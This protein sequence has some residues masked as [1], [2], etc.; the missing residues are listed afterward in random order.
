MKL[1]QQ[2]DINFEPSK[3]LAHSY[4]FCTRQKKGDFRG[5]FVRHRNPKSLGVK[6]PDFIDHRDVTFKG[7]PFTTRNFAHAVC[8]T[9]KRGSVISLGGGA[10]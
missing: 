7:P 10:L 4:R 2:Y 5:P 1:Q 6:L 8:W 9:L 3:D